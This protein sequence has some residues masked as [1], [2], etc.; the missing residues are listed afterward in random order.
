[1]AKLCSECG[2]ESSNDDLCSNCGERLDDD[3]VRVAAVPVKTKTS[4]AVPRPIIQWPMSRLVTVLILVYIA[5][6]CT[7]AVV[8]RGTPANSAGGV[9]SSSGYADHWIYPRDGVELM[10]Y[11]NGT[12]E[13]PAILYWNE[14]HFRWHQ[15]GDHIVF[16]GWTKGI[17]YKQAHL[18]PSQEFLTLDNGGATP[19]SME[20]KKTINK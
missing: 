1:M 13:T 5:G 20:R 4:A 14:D 2:A 19:I 18:N 8:H 10:I 12:A 15:E 3:P 16:D 11:P 9:Q 7:T 17:V 6:M